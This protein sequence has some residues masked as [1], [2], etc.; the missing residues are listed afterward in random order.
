MSK[1]SPKS[2]KKS[3]IRSSSPKRQQKTTKDILVE[4]Y[5]VLEKA[6]LK[7]ERVLDLATKDYKLATQDYENA[8]I[9]FKKTQE[10]YKKVT[11]AL[12]DLD[13]AIPSGKMTQEAQK[14]IEMAERYLQS[15]K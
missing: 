4:A 1:L 15:K 6:S 13:R 3:P 2:L 14:A 9:K 8:T 10:S 12:R 7:A 11:N 5:K